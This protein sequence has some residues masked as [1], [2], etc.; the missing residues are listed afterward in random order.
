MNCNVTLSQVARAI[1]SKG[2]HRLWV[3]DE[4]GRP[5]HVISLTDVMRLLSTADQVDA[6]KAGG[7]TDLRQLWRFE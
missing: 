7:D 3:V 6:R 4:K 5:S 2:L 1:A